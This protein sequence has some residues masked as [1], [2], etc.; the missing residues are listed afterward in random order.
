MANW[1]KINLVVLLDEYENFSARQQRTVNTLLKFHKD[2]VVYR[3]GMRLEGFRTYATVTKDD[4][5]KEGRDYQKAV[6][7]DFL[8]RKRTGFT[9]YLLEIARKRLRSISHL[10]KNGLTDI[11]K[12]LG[13]RE[14]LEKEALT[15]AS[16]RSKKMFRRF[17]KHLPKGAYRSLHTTNKP[18]LDMMAVLYVL[19]GESVASVRRA[20]AEYSA[21]EK[22][23]A[24]N[25]IR[26]DLSNKYKLSLVILL[27]SIYRQ[28]KS[29]YSFNTFAFLSSGIVGHFLEMC[30][31]SFRHAEFE[32]REGLLEGR[33]S[34]AIQSKAARE[35]ATRELQQVKRI[36]D[37]GTKLYQMAINLGNIFREYHSDPFVRY[38]EMN[39]FSLDM[40]ELEPPYDVAF[41]S[42][43]KWSVI[44][45]KNAL[46]SGSPGSGRTEIFTLSRAFSP[47]FELTYRTRGGI[48]EQFDAKDMLALMT[49]KNVKPKRDLSAR[50]DET[51][52]REQQGKLGL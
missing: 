2:H 28:K 36:E 18:L 9:E 6:F 49:T 31:L 38:P 24:A 52:A 21:G 39:Q 25:R 29:Y 40:L 22:T 32:D 13:K 23:K 4:F 33:I 35:F 50:L 5:I 10:E 15:L 17:E 27:A 43:I 20:I 14:S 12:F 46:Q 44:Q 51:K 42:A 37:H 8:N 11:R 7:D 34:P 45:R 47:V 1:A 16:D 41:R 48:N 30:R 3:V 26:Y 19:R